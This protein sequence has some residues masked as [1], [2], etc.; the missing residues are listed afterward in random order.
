MSSKKIAQITNKLEKILLHAGIDQAEF[1]RRLG[2]T[3]GYASD[4]INGK[5]I[6][7]SE[8][9]AKLICREFN[10]DPEWFYC[11]K[12]EQVAEAIPKHELYAGWKLSQEL[13]RSEDRIL[14]EKALETITSETIYSSAL[15]SNINAFYQAMKE[16]M[17]K[18]PTQKPTNE[19]TEKK[20]M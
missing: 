14:L 10:L 1:A 2:I 19:N 3:S 16:A 7:I 9:L 11:E 13:L 4:L 5:K 8:T 17:E 18:K 20:I 6:I 15:I 12:D